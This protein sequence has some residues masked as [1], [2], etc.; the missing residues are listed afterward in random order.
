MQQFGKNVP[1]VP[2]VCSFPAV[3]TS[4]HISHYSWTQ[5]VVFRDEK[6][7]AARVVPTLYGNN[8]ATYINLFLPTG[9]IILFHK[10]S[11]AALC[12]LA[13]KWKQS[14]A[15]YVMSI[16]LLSGISGACVFVKN[17]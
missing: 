15:K 13:E 1:Q 7:P 2:A 10:A 4:L 16:V 9:S 8:E 14:G 5:H 12:P 6:T 11:A 17:G 3:S